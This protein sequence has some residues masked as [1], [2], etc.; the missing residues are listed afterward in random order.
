MMMIEHIHLPHPIGG[1]D[2][3]R[4]F[5]LDVM[6]FDEVEKPE[7]IRGEPGG[8]WVR[9][10]GAEVHIGNDP[11]HRPMTVAHPAFMVAD[12]DALA[13]RL[14]FHGHAVDWDDRI[15]DRRR[16][17]SFDPA[18]NRLEFFIDSKD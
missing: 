13:D 1:A 16:F 8:G 7:T 4:A 17:F 9:K 6:R 15:P 12:L 18:G 2:A 14:K 11:D 3:A 10:D 5:W